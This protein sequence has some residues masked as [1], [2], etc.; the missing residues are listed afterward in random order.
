MK[1]VKEQIPS[2]KSAERVLDLLEL[3]SH[4]Q[5]IGL[6]MEQILKELRIPR[7]S[8]YAL[9]RMLIQREYLAKP[10]EG[11]YKLGVKAFEI[12]SAYLSNVELTEIARPIMLEIKN[13]TK[14][15]VNITVFDRDLLEIIVV[16]RETGLNPL[17][18]VSSLGSRLPA[19]KTASGKLFL[20]EYSDEEVE[21]LFK[22]V[23]DDSD[24]SV[25]NQELGDTR[26]LGISENDQ[27]TYAGV[28][29]LAAPILDKTKKM[30]AALNIG[31]PV[32]QL[33]QAKK[34]RY[35]HLLQAGA[36]HIS[37]LMGSGIP[38]SIVDISELKEIWD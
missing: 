20:S 19:I 14:E 8:F 2:I 10:S 1:E 32:Q 30:I 23:V 37:Y 27:K 35:V 13:I 9:S 22:G 24:I 5:S 6:G 11:V 18:F 12:G 33:D 3:L 29:V 16:A 31:I 34:S 26:V 36:S 7:S 4:N 21:S 15:T 28:V 17:R 38:S 25:L